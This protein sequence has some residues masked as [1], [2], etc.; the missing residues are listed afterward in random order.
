MPSQVE[1]LF[2]AGEIGIHVDVEYNVHIIKFQNPI[3]K[4]QTI[5]NNRNSNDQNA[6]NLNV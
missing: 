6:N 1:V 3:I 2:Y 5:S 4:F